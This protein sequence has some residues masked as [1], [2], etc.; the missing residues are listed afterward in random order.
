[1]VYFKAGAPQ[2][3]QK[4]RQE[5]HSTTQ[6]TALLYGEFKS[7]SSVTARPQQ[8]RRNAAQRKTTRPKQIM[9]HNMAADVRQH[10]PV[11]TTAGSTAQTNQPQRNTERAQEKA[12]LV[13]AINK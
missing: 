4:A 3:P 12:I 1:M 5:R 11:N 2:P 9:Q 10:S 7:N 8:A 6:N 13:R